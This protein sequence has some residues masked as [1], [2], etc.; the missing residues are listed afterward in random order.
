MFSGFIHV[1]ACISSFFLLMTK[2]YSIVWVYHILFIHSLIN[3]HWGC[4]CLWSNM[5]NAT[6]N[7]HVQVSVWTY[8]FSCLEYI[9]SVELLSHMLTL[10]NR[11]RKCQAIFQKGFIS[12]YSHSQ[13]KRVFEMCYCCGHQR[14]PSNSSGDLVFLWG[15]WGLGLESSLCACPQERFC[16]LHLSQYK[17]LLLSLEALA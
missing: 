9:P 8:V 15:L 13:C 17:P 16:L 14:P 4:L 3:G 2:W 7:I 11:V 12:L 6:V 10:V 1:R 5:D